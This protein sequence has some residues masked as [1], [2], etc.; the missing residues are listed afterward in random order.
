M[1][2]TIDWLPD[3]RLLIVSGR[4]GRV[5]RREADGSLATHA[6]LTTLSEKPWNDIVVD[7]KGN[8]YVGNMGF[9]FPTEE[10][11]PG[12]LALVTPTAPA[13]R[14]PRGWHSPTARSSPTTSPP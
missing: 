1:P 14:W 11:D 6:D 12:A 9:A 4:E 13:A 3:G 10:F 7:R 2:F 5:L 8:A